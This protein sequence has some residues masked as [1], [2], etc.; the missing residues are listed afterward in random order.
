M[1]KVSIII[2]VYNCENYI[3]KSIE[4][5][6]TQKYSN[7]EVIVVDDGSTDNSFRICEKI[8]DADQRVQLYTKKNGGVS[9][10]RNVGLKKATGDYIMFLDADDYIEKET[11]YECMKIINKYKVDIVKFNF[12]KELNRVRI[13]NKKIIDVDKKIEKNFEEI[14]KKIFIVDDFCSSC[15]CMLSR[16]VIKNIKFDEAI[17]LGEDFL[18]FVSCLL[19][20]ESI[21]I[22]NNCYYHYIVN[23]ASATHIFDC[24]GNIEK[25]ENVIEISKIIQDKIKDK[26]N[27]KIDITPKIKRNIVDSINLCIEKTNM[28]SVKKYIKMLKDNQIIRE[29]INEINKKS[30]LDILNYKSLNFKVNYYKIRVKR[31]VKKIISK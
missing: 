5:V 18:F 11:I 23:S 30:K 2:P 15:E 22:T 1:K 26:L 27:K 6:L 19:E 29:K 10:A 21:Y 3:E 24:E 25:L 8:K 20:S 31:L 28:A 7:L 9:S 12:I 13:K 14:I 17:K 16:K 4:S